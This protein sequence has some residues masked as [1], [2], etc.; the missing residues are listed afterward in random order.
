MRKAVTTILL[1]IAMLFG[2]TTCEG[3]YT[4]PNTLEM[5]GGGGGFGGYGG[6]L[7]FR[8]GTP[9]SSS[10]LSSAQFNAI[11]KAAGGGYKG[12]SFMSMPMRSA[13]G[14]GDGYQGYSG[15][16]NTNS[17]A[18]YGSI[19]I[20]Y[21]CW[22]NRQSGNFASMIQEAERQTGVPCVISIDFTG[23][24]W[25]QLSGGGTYSTYLDGL[26]F[27][28]FYVAAGSDDNVYKV[29]WLMWVKTASS[30]LGADF[31]NGDLLFVY[32]DL[33]KFMA[34]YGY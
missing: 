29:W 4:D 28:D 17:R 31:K 3:P 21:A 5:G 8:S 6:M 25:T 30:Y 33:S 15:T 34:Q 32:M 24:W 2:F 23:N 12:Y 11:N 27:G 14:A 16:D 7:S 1:L 22:E 20:L 10:G 13:R 18:A 26:P 9:P 19:G